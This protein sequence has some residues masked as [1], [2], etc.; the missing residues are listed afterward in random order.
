MISDNTRK[1]TKKKLSK[2]F[3]DN[4]IDKIE[5][6]F[7]D[8]AKCYCKKIN[9]KTY[10]K[11]IYLD[12]L[13][14]ILYNF[15]EGKNQTSKEIISNVKKDKINPYDIAFYTPEQLNY[16]NWEII[17][18]KRKASEDSLKNLP[19]ITWKPCKDCKNNKYHF[20]NMQTR[21]ADEPMTTFY[22][23][24]SCGRNYKVNN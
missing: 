21:R 14:N 8:Y 2:Y 6:G 19:T 18:T 15:N 1:K 10:L 13:D 20:Y 9:D 11:S 4:K 23:C 24:C 3:P 16:E 5:K 22:I 12:R 17:I 7:Y